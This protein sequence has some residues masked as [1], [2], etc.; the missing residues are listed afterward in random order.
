M[1]TLKQSIRRGFLWCV[2][3]LSKDIRDCET[4]EI[5]GRGFF[6][7]WGAAIWLIGYSGSPLIPKFLPQRR[8]TYWKQSIGFTTTEKPDF[9]RMDRV[10]C[11]PFPASPRVLNL[12]LTHLDGEHLVRLRQR[13]AG[14]CRE[15]DL[16]IAFG[17]EKS[18][19]GSLGLERKVF[20]DEGGLK[21][22]D[23]QREM[24]SYTGIFRAMAP[25]IERERPDFIYLCEYDHLP[26]RPDLKALQVAEIIAE[27]ADV[28]GHFLGRIDGTG[29]PHY[30]QHSADPDFHRYWE[31]VSLRENKQVV[32]TMFGS[33]SFWS[34]EAF[35]AI[36]KQEQKIPCYVELYLPTM[37]H[38]LGFRVRCWDETRHMISNLPSRKWT[39]EAARNRSFLSIHPVK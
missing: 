8:L 12:V 26:L 35:L 31:S 14:V 5:L 6:L 27:R 10:G 32:L 34:R 37:A 20:V 25:V 17:G 24:Q 22:M 1:N 29:H 38:H 3:F 2:G 28:M 21:R 36:S 16:W 23:N 15:E 9:P 33:G 18:R 7:G 4:G 11:E 30:L 19:Y 39:I 13:W